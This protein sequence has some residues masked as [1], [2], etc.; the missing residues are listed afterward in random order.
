M[1]LNQN[2]LK[3]KLSQLGILV[4]ISV[5]LVGFSAQKTLA[6]PIISVLDQVGTRAIETIFGI[7]SNS[8]QSPTNQ[9]SPYPPN[10]SEPIPNYPSTSPNP[11]GAYP[12]TTSSPTYPNTSG[13]PEQSTPSAY[14]PNSPGRSSPS[15]IINNY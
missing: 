9:T 5:S 6:I 3:H 15:I 10:A 11:A 13:Y 1:V 4:G 7:N 8:Q 14:P 12:V 2:I